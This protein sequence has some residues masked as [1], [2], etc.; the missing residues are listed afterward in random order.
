VLPL[1]KGS[2]DLGAQP[3]GLAQ[4]ALRFDLH[5]LDIPVRLFNT[6]R[7]GFLRAGTSGGVVSPLTEAD[8]VPGP[9]LDA[10]LTSDTPAGHPEAYVEV[11]FFNAAAA[12]PAGFDL[13]DVGLTCS[14]R[15]RCSRCWSR[16]RR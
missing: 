8:A 16:R 2:S 6:S 13:D 11:D 7:P 5:P 9:M 4:F 15:R 14:C 3:A 12:P 1:A 10:R